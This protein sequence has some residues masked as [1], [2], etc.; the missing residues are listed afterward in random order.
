QWIYTF[1]KTSVSKKLR[2]AYE[3]KEFKSPL[4]RYIFS[5]TLKRKVPTTKLVLQM[6]ELVT[7]K[8][9]K[10]ANKLVFEFSGAAPERLIASELPSSS[11]GEDAFESGAGYRGEPLEKL[12]LK[13]TEVGEA[14]KL[15]LR[16]T[17]YNVVLGDDVKGNI[18]SLSL[19][20][21]PWDQALHIILQMKKLG[22][23][24]RGNIVRIASLDTLKFEQAELEKQEDLEPLKT[25]LLPV[26]YAKANTL[27]PRATPF[28]SK[29]GKIDVDDRTNTLI[30][31]DSESII[32]R[33][34]KLFSVLDTQPPMIS[35][36]AKFLEVKKSFSRT[37]GLGSMS[38]AGQTSGINFGT[39]QPPLASPGLTAGASG[40]SINLSAPKF[41]ALNAQLAVAENQNKAKTLSNPTIVVQQGQSGNITQGK[42][43]N[44][45]Q[46]LGLGGAVTTPLSVTANLTLTVTPVV[47]NDGSI[48]LDTNISDSTADTAGGGV[49][50][51]N[52]A[53][54]T[55]IIL[56]NGDTAVLG[57]VTAGNETLT[58]GGIP[59]FK[60]LPLLGYLFGQKIEKTDQNEVLIFITARI[61]NPDAAFKQTI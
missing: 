8:V 55:Q 47:A 20:N 60:D 17:G 4:V 33:L 42:T 56:Q 52:R 51:S 61:L 32:T 6:R 7:P 30:I 41:A 48:S 23:V 53:L 59:F 34:Q 18:G 25:V 49:T 27:A 43:F 57:G 14:I 45:P 5:Q 22:F 24:R 39:A 10:V 29:R 26:S 38:L 50:T 16:S 35:I 31:R 3:T 40:G 54:R 2:R 36:S 28:L 1:D 19:R 11:L 46:A 58:S 37:L 9:T 13:N 44:I 21:I 12:E 15:V